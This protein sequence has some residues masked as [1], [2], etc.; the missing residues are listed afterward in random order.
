MQN[1]LSRDNSIKGFE[2]KIKLARNR[3]AD[4]GHPRQ[5]SGPCIRNEPFC[6]FSKTLPSTERAQNLLEERQQW[7]KELVDN[8]T[9]FI[10][11][12]HRRRSGEFLSIKHGWT[13]PASR[14]TGK[15]DAC[16]P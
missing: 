1:V 12:A 13:S 11:V 9:A 15:P 6:W 8:A 3:R 14:P 7:F 16:I 10:W 4:H 2:V 5:K